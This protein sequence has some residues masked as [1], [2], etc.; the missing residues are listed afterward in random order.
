GLVGLVAVITLLRRSALQLD[1]PDLRNAV[2]VYFAALILLLILIGQLAKGLESA[3]AE[4]A[5]RG[6]KEAV[7]R[8]RYTLLSLWVGMNAIFASWYSVL[9]AHLRRAAAGERL[10]SRAEAD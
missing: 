6:D 1:R 5:A 7:R 2:T 8:M 3:I 4:N 9:M 10:I